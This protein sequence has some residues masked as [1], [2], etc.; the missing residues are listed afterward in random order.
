MIVTRMRTYPYSS[1]GALDA[2]G[3]PTLSQ[4]PVGEVKMAIHIASQSV[5]ETVRY[6][7]CE[8]MGITLSKNVNDAMVIHY[9]DERLK[10]LYVNPQGRYKQVF[11]KR[12]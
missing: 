9:G 2:Y 7:E 6:S 3:Q 4:E 8:Y 1:F 11:L 10:V 5:S 12:V